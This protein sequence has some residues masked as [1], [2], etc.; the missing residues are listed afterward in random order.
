MMCKVLTLAFSLFCFNLFGASPSFQQVTNIVVAY[1][2]GL[3]TTNYVN[4][5]VQ[6]ATNNF[7]SGGS[8]TNGDSVS[9]GMQETLLYFTNSPSSWTNTTSYSVAARWDGSDPAVLTVLTNTA[10]NGGVA[11]SDSFYLGVRTNEWLTWNFSG[12]PLRL[13][14]LPDAT[15]L[16]YIAVIVTGNGLLYD[17]AGASQGYLCYDEAGANMGHLTYDL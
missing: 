17:E 9:N 10:K 8:F 16:Q 1:T 15:P 2:N 5:T 4:T 7:V 11:L 12:A 3:A 13:A 14:I 6:S